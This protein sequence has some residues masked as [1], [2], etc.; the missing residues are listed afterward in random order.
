M[1]P[2]MA[3]RASDQIHYVSVEMKDGRVVLT[4][5]EDPFLAAFEAIAPRPNEENEEDAH[6][7]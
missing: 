5:A 2:I 4:P 3:V 6:G 7:S 1:T